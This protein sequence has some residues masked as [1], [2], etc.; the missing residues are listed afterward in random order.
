MFSQRNVN[1]MQYM[2]Q[3]HMYIDATKY[4]IYYLKLSYE[5]LITLERD[6][7]KQILK[8]FISIKM[9]LLIPL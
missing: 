5:N 7:K 6:K 2:M 3:I 9:L 1:M 8:I 4:L